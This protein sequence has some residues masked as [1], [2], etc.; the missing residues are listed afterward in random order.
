MG[1]RCVPGRVPWPEE[2]V[3]GN[4]E[5]ASAL[6]AQAEGRAREASGCCPV[7]QFPGRSARFMSS[8]GTEREGGERGGKT[9]APVGAA[10]SRGAA[11]S[12]ARACPGRAWRGRRRQRAR[13][14]GRLWLRDAARRGAERA[15]RGGAESSAEQPLPAAAAD[16][17]PRPRLALW[18]GARCCSLSRS[19][20]VGWVGGAGTAPA[21]ALPPL[22]WAEA[23]ELPESRGPVPAPRLLSGPLS[24][25]LGPLPD[26]PEEGEPD[27]GFWGG[28]GGREI[29]LRPRPYLS[30]RMGRA[31]MRWGGP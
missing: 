24:C 22:G 16:P 20:C 6:K 4:Q 26:T 10:P 2:G 21:A 8:P 23:T 1:L 7:T 3:P 15:G 13:G 27:Q 14:G 5:G 18:T 17:G 19:R 9:R 31:E 28:I 11:A 12:R 25:D 29:V 30:R